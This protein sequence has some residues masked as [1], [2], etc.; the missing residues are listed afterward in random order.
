M[1]FSAKYAE[2][3]NAKYAEYEIYAEYVKF[4]L[5]PTLMMGHTEYPGDMHI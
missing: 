1:N 3:K 5:Y 2:C 4:V